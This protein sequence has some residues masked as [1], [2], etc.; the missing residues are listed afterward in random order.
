MHHVCM[1]L[2]VGAYFML[3]RFLCA[4]VCFFGAEAL[5]FGFIQLLRLLHY[6]VYFSV[7]DFCRI[8][9]VTGEISL[10]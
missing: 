4:C 2:S 5:S 1:H 7:S 3:T 10:L 9:R 8:V 6:R